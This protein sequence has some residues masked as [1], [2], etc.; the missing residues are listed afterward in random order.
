MVVPIRMLDGAEV[1]LDQPG[2]GDDRA[3]ARPIRVTE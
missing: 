3:L 1:Q 2:A